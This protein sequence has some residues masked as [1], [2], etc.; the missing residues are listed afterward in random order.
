MKIPKMVLRLEREVLGQLPVVNLG[1]RAHFSYFSED[2]Y[3]GENNFNYGDVENYDYGL[4]A[5]GGVSLGL[6]SPYVGL[7]LGAS[8]LEVEQNDVQ[9]AGESDSSIYWNGFIGAK[10]SPIPN[11]KPFVEYRFED[12]SDYENELNDVGNSSGRL[13][14][15]ISLSF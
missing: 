7:G 13:I 1:L 5:V 8:T 2:N 10:V 12:V 6:L 4:A 14:F 3:V 9:N 15:G 11:I